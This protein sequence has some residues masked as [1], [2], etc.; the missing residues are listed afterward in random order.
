MYA[1]DYKSAGS[2][3]N[4]WSLF[5]GNNTRN[6]YY[7]SI[8]SHG[9]LDQNNI[10]NILDIISLVNIIIGNNNLDD[11]EL[12]QI[13]LNGDGNVNVLDIIIITNIILE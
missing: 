13:D 12:C 6:G 5:K 4:Y 3:D 8:C 1:I 2:S 10:I 7:F 11:Y 9:D